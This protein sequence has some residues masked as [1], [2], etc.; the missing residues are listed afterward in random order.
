M[1]ITKCV[2]AVAYAV[3]AA[4]ITALAVWTVAPLHN[5]VDLVTAY[6][7]SDVLLFLTAC[8]VLGVGVYSFFGYTRRHKAHRA[9]SWFFITVGAALLVFAVI[10]IC[11]FGGITEE[12]FDAA[13]AAALNLN[14]GAASVVPLPFLVRGWILACTARFSRRERTVSCVAMAVATAVYAA[15]IIGGQLMFQVA[16]SVN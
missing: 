14:I 9:D 7:R 5:T 8:S 1:K 6:W 4:C 10:V 3:L 13:A 2:K 11:R 12:N 16:P 15:V